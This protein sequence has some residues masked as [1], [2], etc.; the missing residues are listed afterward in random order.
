MFPVL[1]F[2]S[3]IKAKRKVPGVSLVPVPKWMTACLFLFICRSSNIAI[4]E[5]VLEKPLLVPIHKFQV[6]LVHILWPVFSDKSTTSNCQK[7]V[8]CWDYFITCPQKTFWNSLSFVQP[9]FMNVES[10]FW[11]SLGSLFLDGNLHLCRNQV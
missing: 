1:V 5:L 7:I 10:S 11:H 4:R 8:Y 6:F 9:H 3:D 2:W